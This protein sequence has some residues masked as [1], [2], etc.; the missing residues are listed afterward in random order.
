MGFAELVG[1]LERDTEARVAEVRA[2]ADAEVAALAAGARRAA[3]SARGDALAVRRRERRAELA[4]AI[5]EV[6]RSA[7][8][9]E[10]DAEHAAIE[11]GL[12]RARELLGEVECRPDYLASVPDRVDQALRYLPP[13][14]ARIQCRP[15]LAEAVARA[16]AGHADVTVEVSAEMP[17]GFTVSAR[18]GSV[19]VDCTLSALLGR[20]RPRLRAD[21]L[22]ALLP[23]LG[24]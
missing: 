18:D 5:A 9:A 7:R 10:L 17:A 11:R 3:E 19:A 6:R 4:R 15:A 1:R 8:L 23:E 16:A 22:R 24:P 14:E 13:G 2:H 20:L 12:A 21:L